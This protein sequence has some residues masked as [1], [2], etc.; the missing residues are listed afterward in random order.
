MG[1]MTVGGERLMALFVG[2][3][4]MA[5]AFVALETEAPKVL[6]ERRED[7][8]IIFSSEGFQTRTYLGPRYG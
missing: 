4:G 8:F 2:L 5:A 6:L 3:C 7:M 1:V